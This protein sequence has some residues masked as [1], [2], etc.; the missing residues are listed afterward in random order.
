MH[1][2]KKRHK[3]DLTFCKKE[4]DLFA[5][6]DEFRDLRSQFD[7]GYFQPLMVEKPDWFQYM[8]K[9]IEEK[10]NG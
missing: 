2:K 7:F 3:R 4:V 8:I 1:R 9:T 5:I 6:R 10:I